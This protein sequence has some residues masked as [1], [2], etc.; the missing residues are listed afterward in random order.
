[1]QAKEYAPKVVEQLKDSDTMQ[2]CA[3]NAL[4]RC[5][6]EYAPK[7]V[8]LLKDSD[9]NVSSAAASALWQMQAKEYAPKVAELFKFLTQMSVLSQHQLVSYFVALA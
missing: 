9:T 4:G 5:S 1:M 2:F 6:Q 8:E 3:A 7:V